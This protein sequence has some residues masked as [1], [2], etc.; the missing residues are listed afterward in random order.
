MCLTNV[1]VLCMRE[2]KKTGQDL[3][4]LYKINMNSAR[5]TEIKLRPK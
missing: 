4:R 5:Q 1:L 3:N 2:P